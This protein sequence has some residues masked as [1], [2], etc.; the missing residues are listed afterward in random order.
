MSIFLG[1][2]WK[3]PQIHP[4]VCTCSFCV[5]RGLEGQL[6]LYPLLINRLHNACGNSPGSQEVSRGILL[7]NDEI[8][9][10]NVNL[11]VL[12][13]TQ[14]SR[15]KLSRYFLLREIFVATVEVFHIAGATV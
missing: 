3:P 12:Y 1:F 11:V 6:D 8:L 9:N 7:S 5:R 2:Y 4:F 13:P 14:N 10:G 15:S